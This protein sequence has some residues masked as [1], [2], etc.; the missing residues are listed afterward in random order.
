MNFTTIF[1]WLPIILIVI[2]YALP[3]IQVM[4]HTKRKHEQQNEKTLAK[5]KE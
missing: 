3:T 4:Y 1:K 5:N 2:I